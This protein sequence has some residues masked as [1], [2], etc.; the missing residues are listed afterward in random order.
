MHGADRLGG[1]MLTSCLIFGAR[2]GQAAADWARIHSVNCDI[3]RVAHDKLDEIHAINASSGTSSPHELLQTLQ[4]SAWN[5]ALTIRS[6]SRLIAMRSEIRQLWE[7][8]QTSLAIENP[9]DLLHAL[10]LRNLLLV[11]EIVVTAALHRQESRGGHYRED[12]PECAYQQP[13]KAITLNQSS[14]RMIE[15]TEEL[16]DPHWQYKIGDLGQ[17]RWG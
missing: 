2:A 6:E 17:D 15:V 4:R 12:F 9:V 11:G 16:I 3:R 13:V 7:A 10:E 14:D 8:Y 5:N 1:N